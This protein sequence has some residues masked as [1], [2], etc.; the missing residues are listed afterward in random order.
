M[1]SWRVYNQSQHR[2]R[3]GGSFLKKILSGI[4]LILVLGVIFITQLQDGSSSN[5]PTVST[6]DSAQVQSNPSQN[7]TVDSTKPNRSHTSTTKNN[8]NQT[9]SANTC[10]VINTFDGVADYL[11][12]YKKLPCNYITKSQAQALGWESSKGNL[13]KV[14][15][16]KSIGGD[17]FSN[18]EKLL[19]TSKG[20]K[21]HEADI[22]YTSGFRG[23]NR[24]L[25]STDGLIYKTT[26]HYDSFQP[27][28]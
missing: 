16:G 13:D 27:I 21:W 5:T 12:E 8:N 28:Q 3:T 2:D 18:Y 1:L 15:P 7:Q 17:Y 10:K 24:I 19:P 26:D 11:K 14:A 22:N 25:Y 9:N 20:R 4:V 6:N 23:A